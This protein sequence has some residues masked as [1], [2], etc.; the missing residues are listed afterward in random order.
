M[1]ILSPRS[2][3]PPIAH[4]AQHAHQPSAPMPRGRSARAHAPAVKSNLYS[5][6]STRRG[7]LEIRS[8]PLGWAYFLTI[9]RSSPLLFR[10]IP[11]SNSYVRARHLSV[12]YRDQ[13]C[14]GSIV[15]DLWRV[16]DRCSASR[17][18]KVQPPSFTAPRR[19]PFVHPI[20]T[21]LA[22]GADL[23]MVVLLYY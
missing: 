9:A 1:L 10:L 11:L 20:H 12:T 15:S 2:L 13:V 6:E 18:R 17:A 16:A 8:A 3:P 4:R 19:P 21:Y 7:K 22:T 14:L 23:P 5:W